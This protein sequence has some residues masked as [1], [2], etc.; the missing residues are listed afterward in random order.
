MF[1][2]WAGVVVGGNE[3]GLAPSSSPAQ[4]GDPVNKK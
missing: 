1:E 3:S 4:A 2:K